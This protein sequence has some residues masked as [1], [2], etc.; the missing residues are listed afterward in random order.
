MVFAIPEQI[1]VQAQVLGAMLTVGYGVRTG[2]LPVEPPPAAD[3]NTMSRPELALPVWRSTPPLSPLTPAGQHALISAN[4]KG[5][6]SQAL[7]VEDSSEDQ[8]RSLSADS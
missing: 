6:A 3:L 8:G 5:M 7:S 2:A 1:R 4:R